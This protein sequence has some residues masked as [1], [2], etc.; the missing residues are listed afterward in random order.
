[1]ENIVREAHRQMIAE[2]LRINHSYPSNWNAMLISGIIDINS[3][4][5][6]IVYAVVISKHIMMEFVQA[7]SM[8][9]IL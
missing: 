5:L 8:C 9:K 4:Y 7:D 3:M 6:C 2:E 1:M